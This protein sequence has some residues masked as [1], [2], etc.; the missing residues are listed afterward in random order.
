MSEDK[1]SDR[2]VVS[3]KDIKRDVQ[4]FGEDSK[5]ALRVIDNNKLNTEWRG[6]SKSRE[7]R[8]RVV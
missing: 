7:L 8:G 3:M 5:G 6:D 2:G 1:D 4:F